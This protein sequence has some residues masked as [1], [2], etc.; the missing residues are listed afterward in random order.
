MSE[1][2]LRIKF[3]VALSN[4][5]Y[6]FKTLLEQFLLNMWLDKYLNIFIK[7]IIPPPFLNLLASVLTQI[8]VSFD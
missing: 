4:S 3:I 8:Y 5:E 6:N 7:P 2:L 1:S